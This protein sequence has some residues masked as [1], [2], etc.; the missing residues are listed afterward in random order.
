MYKDFKK[1]E[2]LDTGFV[3]GS[4]IIWMFSGIVMGLLVGI[5]MYYFSNNNT[6][7]LSMVDSVQKKIE[8]AQFSSPGPANVRPILTS[9][10]ASKNAV[11]TVD[12][13]RENKFSFYAV[14]PTI[15]V[16]VGSTKP[17]D[18]RIEGISQDQ[19][20]TKKINTLEATVKV[21]KDQSQKSKEAGR[22]DYLLQVASFKK[23]S[24]ANQTRGRLSKNG[25]EAYVQ[26]RKVK[27]RFWYR[28]VAGPVDQ[29]SVTNW[30]HTAERLGH[31]PLIISVR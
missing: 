11:K 27:G 5:G 21:K 20:L 29:Y 15:G 14:L 16:P 6:S 23:K 25:I 9:S 12:Q 24:K 26:K 31:R 8:K 7:T 22:G 17:F 30:K 3:G 18:P 4:G 1:S 13:Q 2:S 28:V 10:I 19:E